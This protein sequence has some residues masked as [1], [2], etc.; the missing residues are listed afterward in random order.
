MALRGILSAT[1]YVKIRAN[2]FIVRHIQSGREAK[3]RSAQ[4]FTTQRLLIGDF[5][6]AERC[7]SQAFREVRYGPAYFAAPTVVMHPLEMMEG[8]ISP[9][10]ERVLLEVAHG[11][12]AKRTVVW[13]GAELSDIQV[14]EKA[15]AA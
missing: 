15:K 2:E 3:V 14:E 13:I 8:G 1:V 4:P 9:I 5:L 6:V 10:E 11:A 7:L 12:G